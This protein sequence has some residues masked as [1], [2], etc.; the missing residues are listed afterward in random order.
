MNFTYVALV[1]ALFAA[2]LAEADQ[3]T[4]AENM[5]LASR[6][7]QVDGINGSK[8][9]EILEAQSP[10]VF[11]YCRQ[12]SSA[13]W[14]H[15]V[16]SLDAPDKPAGATKVTKDMSVENNSEHCRVEG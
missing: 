16:M 2:A 4:E 7:L 15:E 9:V 10:F 14:K 3:K 1:F 13:L 6:T 8:I 12:G 11:T 5:A